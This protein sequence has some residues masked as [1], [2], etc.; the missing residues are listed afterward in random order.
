[1]QIYPFQS[2]IIMTTD[3]YVRYGGKTGTFSEEQLQIAYHIA[4]QQVSSYI[5][6]LLLPQ[7]VTGTFSVPVTLNQKRISTDYGYVNQILGVR[8]L[9]KSPTA[10]LTGT[11][12]DISD[13][14]GFIYNDTFGYIDVEKIH[15]L[16]GGCGYSQYPYQFQV[17]YE[18]GLPTGVSTMPAMLSAMTLATMVT[19][20]DLYPGI[21][22]MNEGVGDVGIQEFESIS[23]RERRTAHALR[24]TSFGGSAIANKIAVLIDSC[25]RKARKSLR[26]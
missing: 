9:T 14:I 2:P 24:R 6:T 20:N 15:S 17:I 7:I 16:C 10:S 18:A 13:G 21:I 25:V 23:Y 4:E 5:G 11:L 1:M 3:I 19:L 26:I 8:I 12:Y 22:G